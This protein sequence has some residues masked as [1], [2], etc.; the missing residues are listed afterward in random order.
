MTAGVAIHSCS[1]EPTGAT[2]RTK[3][4]AR[5]TVRLV[6]CDDLGAPG[7]VDTPEDLTPGK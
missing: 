5:T 4:C 1:V 7:D 2:S 6:P 3:A